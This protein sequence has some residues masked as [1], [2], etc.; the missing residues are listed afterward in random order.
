[1]GVG[2]I[3]VADEARYRERRESVGIF[4]MIPAMLKCAGAG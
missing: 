4:A 3:I 1:M 2:G